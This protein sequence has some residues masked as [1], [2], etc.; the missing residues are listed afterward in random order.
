[1]KRNEED[2]VNES[3][4]VADGDLDAD[5]HTQI[6]LNIGEAEQTSLNLEI[7]DNHTQTGLFYRGEEQDG[8]SS[9]QQIDSSQ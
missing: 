6:G 9:S 4:M 3:S 7:A 8:D 5:N 2:G 1:M